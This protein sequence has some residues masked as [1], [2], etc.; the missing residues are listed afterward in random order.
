M[1]MGKQ[2]K[3]QK[4]IVL[5]LRTPLGTNRYSNVNV[6]VEIM[7]TLKSLIKGECPGISKRQPSSRA[8][9][10]YLGRVCRPLAL[11]KILGL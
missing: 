10:T 9:L 2:A 1:R 4:D 3:G 8:E 7:L 6:R 11:K 5:A